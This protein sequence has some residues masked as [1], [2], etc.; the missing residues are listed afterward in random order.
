[1]I[2]LQSFC[3]LLMVII[4]LRSTNINPFQLCSILYALNWGNILFPS[5]PLKNHSAL[6][7]KSEIYLR[8]RVCG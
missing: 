7:R 3:S 4:L 8:E 5:K 2:P 6:N 1:M